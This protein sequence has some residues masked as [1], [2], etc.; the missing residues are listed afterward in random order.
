MALSVIDLE[1]FFKVSYFDKYFL[2][3]FFIFVKKKTVI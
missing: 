2:N 3:F 1:I